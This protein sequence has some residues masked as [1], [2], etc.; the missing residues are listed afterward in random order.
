MKPYYEHGGITIYNGDCRE[1]LPTLEPQSVRLLWTDP[2]Y[3]HG[4]QDGDLQAARV[5]DNVKG[6]RKREAVAIANDDRNGLT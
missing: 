4:N 3:G 1:V 5:R 2:P 6:A